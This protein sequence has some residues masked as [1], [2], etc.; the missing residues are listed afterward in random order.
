MVTITFDPIETHKKGQR[1]AL[2]AVPSLRPPQ[3]LHP[4]RKSV[5]WAPAAK[6]FGAL[7]ARL[8]T[9][10]RRQGKIEMGV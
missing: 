1:E 6:K 5:Q 8:V 4:R 10:D 9:P 2:E 3:E 7:V